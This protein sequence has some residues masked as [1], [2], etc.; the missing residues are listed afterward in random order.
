MRSFARK[1]V[2]QFW[3]HLDEYYDHVIAHI[4]DARTIQIFG[5]GEGKYELKKRLEAQGLVEH[6][7]VSD[8]ADRLTDL[9]VAIK[10]R[11]YFPARSQFDLS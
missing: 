10:V 11:A 8:S 1:C 3:N 9:Q 2:L 5:P 4:Q 7:E 6:I